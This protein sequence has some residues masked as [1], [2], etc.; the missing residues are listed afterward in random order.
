MTYTPGDAN[1]PDVLAGYPGRQHVP[2][3]ERAY[4]SCNP[5]GCS[6]LLPG[7]PL[8]L[9]SC[10]L[11]ASNAPLSGQPTAARAARPPL[12]QA[13]IREA[14]KAV[15]SGQE[16]SPGDSKRWCNLELAASYAVEGGEVAVG[17]GGW[18]AGLAMAT[19]GAGLVGAPEPVLTKAAGVGLMAGGAALST[20]MTDQLWTHQSAQERVRADPPDP[21]VPYRRQAGEGQADRRQSR[22]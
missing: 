16:L 1:F 8:N 11:M 9:K 18:F 21:P 22:R 14:Q 4:L 20:Y 19:V 5:G 2:A 3:V 13:A 6:G 12:A 17:V 7:T 15:E 10:M